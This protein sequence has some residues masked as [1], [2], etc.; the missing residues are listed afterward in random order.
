MDALW[1]TFVNLLHGLGLHAG[2]SVA[3][4]VQTLFRFLHAVL[5]RLRGLFAGSARVTS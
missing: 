4:V 5:G 1:T 2:S 3:D